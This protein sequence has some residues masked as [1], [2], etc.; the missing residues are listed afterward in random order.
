MYAGADAPEG[1]RLFVN[2]EFYF[3]YMQDEIP[4][5]FNQLHE[6]VPLK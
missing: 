3:N 1:C 4:F 2:N 5:I 6:Q